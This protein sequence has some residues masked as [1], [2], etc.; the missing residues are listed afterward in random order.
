MLQSAT[1]DIIIKIISNANWLG[2]HFC[3]LFSGD[4]TLPSYENRPDRGL[5]FLY[6]KIYM[7]L[8]FSFFI[9]SQGCNDTFK[10]F[11]LIIYFEGSKSQA[12]KS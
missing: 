8:C 2:K 12:L 6:L 1:F 5:N 10:S 3:C 11:F 9:L 7:I 4:L